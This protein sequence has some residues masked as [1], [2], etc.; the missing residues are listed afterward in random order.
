MMNSFKPKLSKRLAHFAHFYQSQNI[1]WD[2]GCDH[3]HLGLSFLSHQA[4]PAIH[5]V[6]PALPVITKLKERIATDI[7]RVKIFHQAGQEVIIEKNLTHFIFIAGMGGLEI[8]SIMEKLLP[9]MKR[10]DLLFIS[11]HNKVLEVREFLQAQGEWLQQE[12]IIEEAGVWYPHFLLGVE[13]R[14][15]SSY[16]QEVF[17][18][19]MGARYRQ[20]LLER[21]SRH[22]DAQSKD[23]LNFIRNI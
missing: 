3:A 16:G 10:G 5:L 21:L 12:D 9:Q 11:P 13:G 6:D 20:Y 8:I 22:Q 17:M 15:I 1:I 4:S 2:I 18:G 14:P 19:E 7:P 23:F